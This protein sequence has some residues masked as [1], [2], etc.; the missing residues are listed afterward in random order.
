MVKSPRFSQAPLVGEEVVLAE[1]LDGAVEL[2]VDDVRVGVEVADRVADVTRLGAHDLGSRQ[3]QRL[4]EA[5]VGV[6]A[7]VGALGGGQA[8][9]ALDDDLRSGVRGGHTRD[10]R[11]Q[12]Q[13][14]QRSVDNP[15]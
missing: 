14:E 5:H 6:G 13:R 2:R 15:R 8:G 10:Q 12:E 3:R 4:D 11:E 9:V 7:D 1:R